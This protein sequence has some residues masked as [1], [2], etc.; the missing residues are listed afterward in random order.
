MN[1]VVKN[2]YFKAAERALQR[3]GGFYS[4]ADIIEGTKTGYFQSFSRGESWAVTRIAKFPQR[5]ALE[6]VFMLGNAE[7]L[8]ELEKEVIK[9]AQSNNIDVMFAYGR[10]GYLIKAFRGWRIVSALFMKELKDG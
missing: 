1:A 10:G 6:V 7:E 8:Q 2:P 4:V 9:F 3:Q 5:T